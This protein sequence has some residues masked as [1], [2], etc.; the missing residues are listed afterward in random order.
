MP[1][2]GKWGSAFPGYKTILK[3]VK[4]HCSKILEK[5]LPFRGIQGQI[6][7]PNVFFKVRRKT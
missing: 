7:D 3:A 4:E 5:F 2:P 6:E 1:K